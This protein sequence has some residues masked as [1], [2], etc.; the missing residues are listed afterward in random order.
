VDEARSMLALLEGKTH[1]VYSGLSLLNSETG[2]RDSMVSC[3]KLRFAT[4]SDREIE[5]YIAS[6]EWQDAAGAYR[7]QGQASYFIESIE[8]SWSCVMG[9]PI[10]ELYGILGRAG[11]DFIPA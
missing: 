9:L 3:T 5:T 8:G 6:G 7:I 2:S 1:R 4:M 10:R 11:Y